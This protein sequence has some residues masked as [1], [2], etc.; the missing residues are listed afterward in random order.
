MQCLC[1]TKHSYKYYIVIRLCDAV[2]NIRC[3]PITSRH[4][5]LIYTEIVSVVA[6]QTVACGYPYESPVVLVYLIDKTAREMFVNI[7]IVAILSDGK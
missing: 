1:T 4:T 3:Q 5:F 7:I 6:V 2:D